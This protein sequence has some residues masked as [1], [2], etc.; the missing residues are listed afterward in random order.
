MA[1][2][3]LTLSCMGATALAYTCPARAARAIVRMFVEAEDC[4]GLLRYPYDNE[5]VPGWYA[6]ISNCRSYGAPGRACHAAIHENSPADRRTI[7][8][9]LPRP[10]P[11]G[12]YRVF[13]RT[14]GPRYPDDDTVVRVHLGKTPVDFRWREGGKRFVWLPGVTVEL[15]ERP[16]SVSFTAVQFGGNG[17]GVLYEPLWRSIWIDTL[18]ITSDL[19]EDVPPDITAERALRAG[20]SPEE[21]SPRPAYRDAAH[22]ARWSGALRARHRADLRGRSALQLPALQPRRWGRLLDRVGPAEPV[23]SPAA[24]GRPANPEHGGGGERSA[25]DR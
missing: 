1:V 3:I 21:L 18:Y 9:R 14:V 4:D 17:H 13:L 7:S 16:R 11:P 5:A 6:R 2:R 8:Q 23:C 20:V 10:L 12:A 25:R 22:A 15:S 19:S 24:R